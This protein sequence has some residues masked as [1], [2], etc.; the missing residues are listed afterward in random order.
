MPVLLSILIVTWAKLSQINFHYFW[1]IGGFFIMAFILNISLKNKLGYSFHFPIYF[2]LFL[3]I[4]ICWLINPSPFKSYTNY[5]NLSKK[6]KPVKLQDLNQARQ[7]DLVELSAAITLQEAMHIDS[8]GASESG[9][10][11]GARGIVPVVDAKYKQGD[12][13][14]A[15]AAFT[16]YV[17]DE[18]NT[19][20]F[21]LDKDEDDYAE[22]WKQAVITAKIEKDSGRIQIYS[23]LMNKVKL[24]SNLIPASKVTFIQSNF[25]SAELNYVAHKLTATGLLLFFLA[26]LININMA[27]RGKK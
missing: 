2:F 16:T 3:T 24:T 25:P 26:A 6:E 17:G 5:Q 19:S 11:N 1:G 21:F 7:F 4:V 22:G 23:Q 20:W 13:I 8:Y 18:G 10:D 12:S 15:Y 9:G 14:Y 27:I